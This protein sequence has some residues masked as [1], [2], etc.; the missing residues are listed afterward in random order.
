[1]RDLLSLGGDQ[2]LFVDSRYDIP[3]QRI[4]IPFVGSPMFTLRH[5][6][7]SGGVQRLPRLIQNVGAMVTVSLLRV[8]YAV[9]PATRKQSLQASLS[10]AR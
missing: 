10:I 9:D 8:E 3:L 4:K 1:M 5:R 6:A 7:G 2:L